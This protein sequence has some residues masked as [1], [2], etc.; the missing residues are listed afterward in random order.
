MYVVVG[1]GG[2]LTINRGGQSA[3]CFAN[4]WFAPPAHR[5]T[6]LQESRHRFRP[7]DYGFLQQ[8]GRSLGRWRH[9]D[10]GMQILSDFRRE[11]EMRLF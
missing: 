8:F 4:L 1:L 2:L 11:I 7:T 10:A 5:S 3:H 6:G 9:T